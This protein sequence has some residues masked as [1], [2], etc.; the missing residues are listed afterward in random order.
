MNAEFILSEL[1]SVGSPEKAKH[2]S[3]FFKTGPGQY[4]EGDR[5][6]GVIVPHSRQI[7]KANKQLPEAELQKLLKSEWHEARL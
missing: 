2:L 3:R 7:A 6:L 1:Q 4:G 5:F